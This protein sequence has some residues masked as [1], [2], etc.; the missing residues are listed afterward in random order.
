MTYVIHLWLLWY[1]KKCNSNSNN[2]WED[3]IDVSPGLKP[4]SQVQITINTYIL[5]FISVW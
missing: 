4:E 2:R 1:F 5:F 3:A